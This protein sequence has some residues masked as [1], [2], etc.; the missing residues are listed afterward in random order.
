MTPILMERSKPVQAT[1]STVN[2]LAYYIDRVMY[3]EDPEAITEL[4]VLIENETINFKDQINVCLDYARSLDMTVTSIDAEIARLK[5]LKEERVQK[6]DKL[7]H[8]VKKYCELVGVNEVVTDVFTVRIKK[9]PA[10]VMI[11]DG[12][13]L[14]SEYLTEK[15]TVAPNKKLIAEHLKAGVCIDG[16]ELVTN[17]RIEIK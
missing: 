1:G 13:E 17:T 3:E 12:V 9:N 6:A 16:V 7:R 5:T 8:A 10:S 4:H 15:I 14:P 2:A 11:H